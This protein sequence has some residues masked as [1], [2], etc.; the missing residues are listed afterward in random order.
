MPSQR[1]RHR[2]G[3]FRFSIL[4]Q[5]PWRAAK[6]DSARELQ[7]PNIPRRRPSPATRNSRRRIGE[8][9]ASDSRYWKHKLN[10]PPSHQSPS[11]ATR[12]SSIP[13]SLRSLIRRI[14]LPRG[15]NH[16][17]I[18]Y[19][20]RTKRMSSPARQM[21]NAANAQLSTGPRTG[22][23]KA[24]SSQNA[25]T[26]GLSAKRLA[27]SALGPPTVRGTPRT[28]P[29]RDQTSRRAPANHLRRTPRLRLEPAPHASHGNRTHGRRAII[30]RL[31]S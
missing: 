29:V 3:R 20:P 14:P 15:Y 2:N 11:T 16:S 26:H 4:R 13:S 17:G 19:D 12:I 21:A 18:Q 25:R 5:V 23:G 31:P 6:S 9:G 24:R 8:I 28:A 22:Q 30:Q 1:V 7:L 27:I 10:P